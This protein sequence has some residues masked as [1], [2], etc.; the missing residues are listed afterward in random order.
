MMQ[1]PLQALP[2][3][4]LSIQLDNNNYDLVIRSTPNTSNIMIADVSINNT[5]VVE[6]QRLVP[7]QFFIPY[8]YMQNGNFTIV[9]DND[10]YP[11]W[12]LF[13]IS[14]YLVYATQSEIEA[15]LNG[16]ST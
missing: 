12:T 9:T 11:D 13:Q 16:T 10:D 1:I 2:N 5:L 8:L 14:Q 6:G 15:I 4:S 7:N 3:Q